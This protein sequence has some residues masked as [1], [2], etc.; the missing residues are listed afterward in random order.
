MS[1]A[2]SGRRMHSHLCWVQR[3]DTLG[4]D[5]FFA[6]MRNCSFLPPSSSFLLL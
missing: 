3:I 6:C 4:F 5:C 1:V 2:N